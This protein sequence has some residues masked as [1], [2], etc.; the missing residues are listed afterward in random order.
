MGRYGSSTIADVTLR[1]DGQIA[2]LRTLSAL[3]TLEFFRS[4]FQSVYTRLQH[5]FTHARRVLL[6]TPKG[7]PVVQSAL[8][9]FLMHFRF[10][11]SSNGTR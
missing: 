3:S 11:G 2:P 7:A 6:Q 10:M 1:P 5:R 9:V 4:R 8:L